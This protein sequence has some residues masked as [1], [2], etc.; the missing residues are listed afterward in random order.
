MAYGFLDVDAFNN[1]R[2]GA[3]GL[4]V[5]RSDG[6]RPRRLASGDRL[7]APA[8]SRDGH[9]IAFGGPDS[10]WLVRPDGTRPHVL[11]GYGSA[12]A[13]LPPA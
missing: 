2:T 7:G 11:W 4:Y 12:P 1:M 10:L 8:W 9:W 6:S 3:S 13:W 5:S